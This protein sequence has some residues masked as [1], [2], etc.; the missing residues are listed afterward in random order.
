MN[1]CQLNIMKPTALHKTSLGFTPEATD[2]KARLRFLPQMTPTVIL[3]VSAR[4]PPA[5]ILFTTGNLGN[6]IYTKHILKE[7]T[8]RSGYCMHS[9]VVLLLEGVELS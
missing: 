1:I 9:M 5:R 6:N 4:S 3:I 7:Y 2:I 8:E